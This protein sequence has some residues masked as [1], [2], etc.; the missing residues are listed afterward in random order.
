MERV[1][2]AWSRGMRRGY[3]KLTVLTLVSK[4]SSSGYDIMKEF[5][6]R[7]LGFW[8]MTTGR[9]YPILQELEEKGYIE[10]AWKSRGKRRRK[11]YAI[12]PRGLQL[13]EVAIK[14]QQQIA[15]I[16]ASLI[17]ECA[18]EILDTNL[19]PPPSLL[20]MNIFAKIERLKEQPIEDQIHTLTH[21]RDQLQI[22]LTRSN[23]LLTQLHAEKTRARENTL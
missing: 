10:G 9:I 13:L 20:P 3:L 7:T 19:S 15:E 14:K 1:A 11:I 8:K 22:L 16:L 12:T 5:H 6:E 23:E 21:H 4:T 17:R 2:E 18:S